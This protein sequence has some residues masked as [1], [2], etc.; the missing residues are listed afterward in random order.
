MLTRSSGDAA[1]SDLHDI[2]NDLSE[3]RERL[4]EQRDAAAAGLRIR[5]W[6]TM[7]VLPLI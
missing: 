3:I 7:F 6:I 4:K 5:M 2:M 1:S